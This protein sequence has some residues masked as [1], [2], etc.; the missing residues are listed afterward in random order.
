MAS[1]KT[2]GKRSNL[3]RL[4]GYVRPYWGIYVAT[5]LLG[6]MKFLLPIIVIWLF[7]EAVGAL[8][9]A[10]SGEMTRREAWGRIQ[11]LF[12][13]GIGIALVTA[14][15]IYLRSYL[16]ARGV[17]RVIRDLRCD[18]YSHVHK[19]SHSFFDRNR[20]GSLT[21]RIISDIQTIQPFLGRT[22]IQLWMNLGVILVILGYFFYENWKLGCLAVAMLPFQLLILRVISPR[23]KAVARDIRQRLAWLSGNTQEKLAATTVVKTFTQEGDEIRRFRNDAEGI[24]SMGLRNAHLSGMQQAGVMFLNSLAPLLVILIGGWLSLFDPEALTVP[25][26]VKFVMMQGQLYA[27]FERLSEAQLVTAQALGAMDRVF[28]IFDTGAE[29]ADRKDAREAPHFEGDIRFENV[30]FSYPEGEKPIIRG[31]ALH[32]PTQTTT[33]LV[34]PSGGGK[35]TL[36]HLLSRFYELDSGRILI[37]G[38]DIRDY[39]VYSLRRQIGLVPQDP[40]LFSGTVEDNILYGRPDASPEEV[41]QAARDAY[42]FD[43]IEQLDDGFATELGE[44]GLRIS[45]GQKQ[46]IAIARAFLKDPAILLL[47]EAT[48]ALDTESERIVQAALRKLMADR[49]TLVIAHRLSTVIHADQIA[50]LEAGLVVERGTH[51]ELLGRGGLYADLYRQQFAQAP[52]EDSALASSS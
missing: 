40:V 39:R 17:H 15:P 48:S 22:L 29:I 31:L 44:R 6:L 20:S 8:V 3:V 19:L 9:A 16:G 25:L 18:L 23:V 13:A 26:L 43:F 33:A 32:A 38:T 12:A 21:S 11:T 1:D 4:L 5:V 7:G 52:G 37:D 34:G 50:V 2:G 46:R 24:V 49:T 35:S 51:Q 30:R 47:D 14:V 41:R 10:E 27:P 28:D 45:G 42:A 36:M